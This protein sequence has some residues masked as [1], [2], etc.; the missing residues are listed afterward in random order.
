MSTPQWWRLPQ[1]A[2][3]LPTS[4][5][6]PKGL[7]HFDGG[8]LADDGGQ[9][10]AIIVSGFAVRW[11]YANE[12]SR[13]ERNLNFLKGRCHGV[14]AFAAT[15]WKDR[16]TDPRFSNDDLVNAIKLTYTRGLRTWLSIFPGPE[17]FDR[18]GR[19]AFVRRLCID[20]Q[21]YQHMLLGID[22]AN[23]P[24]KF[25]EKDEL[26]RLCE[27]LKAAF[28][29]LPVGLGA[30]EQFG[31]HPPSYLYEGSPANVRLTDTERNLSEDGWRLARQGYGQKDAVRGLTRWID[32]EPVSFLDLPDPRI[33]VTKGL[34][35]LLC[36]AAVY[37]VHLSGTGTSFGSPDDLQRGRP[38]NYDEVPGLA[39][40]LEA[41]MRMSARLPQDAA[42]WD[43]PVHAHYRNYGVF[44]FDNRQGTD[45][46]LQGYAPGD[47]ESPRPQDGRLTRW[48]WIRRGQ[49]GFLLSLKHEIPTVGL[50]LWP[51]KVT[52]YDVLAKTAA[53]TSVRDANARLT[54][55]AYGSELYEIDVL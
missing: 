9:F 22:P 34:Q 21:P 51:I 50:P 20:L 39:E 6:Q 48:Y 2:K 7:V 31:D 49:K 12:R 37:C 41:L 52:A 54:L 16:I 47:P 36:G 3:T 11:M 44:P 38:A 18:A 14:R 26:W 46:D 40:T 24:G 42:T 32:I 45:F 29:G 27:I 13:L 35:A 8:N 23:E 1:G 33:H 19:E 15:Y 10:L 28:P 25:L 4:G 30:S 55:P 5:R 17:Y 43:G 53:Y